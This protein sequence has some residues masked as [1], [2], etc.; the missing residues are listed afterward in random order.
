MDSLVRYLPPFCFNLTR[1]FFTKKKNL[2]VIQV[3]YLLPFPVAWSVL[4]T[5]LLLLDASNSR[6]FK[7]KIKYFH[8]RLLYS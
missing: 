2:Q 1:I 8:L 3:S 7:V 4:F 5:L 6:C